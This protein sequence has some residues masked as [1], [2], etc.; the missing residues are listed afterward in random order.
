MILTELLKENL[1]E[2]YRARPEYF[3]LGKLQLIARQILTA[4]STLHRLHIIHCDLKPENILMKSYANCQVK[5]IDI[6]SSSLFHDEVQFYIQTRCY[7]APEVILGCE[8]TEKIDLWSLGCIIAELYSGQVLFE[9][10]NVVGMLAR[11]QG[12][13]GPWPS[14]MIE[15]GKHINKYFTK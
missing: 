11:I 14:W 2:A 12:L 13:R 15:K 8:Y 9:C 10:D 1:Y 7:R 5:V 3:T 4:L 6:G